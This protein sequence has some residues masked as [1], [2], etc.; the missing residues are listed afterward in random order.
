MARWLS[1][2]EVI[3]LP[4]DK[5]VWIQYADYSLEYDNLRYNKETG[6]IYQDYTMAIYT[7]ANKTYRHSWVVWDKLPVEEQFLKEEWRL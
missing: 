3:Q 4:E 1:W 6:D 7:N 5:K 2:E